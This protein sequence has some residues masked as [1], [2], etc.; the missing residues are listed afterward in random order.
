M[1]KISNIL[2]SRNVFAIANFN[3]FNAICEILPKN[4]KQRETSLFPGCLP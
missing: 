4:L 2:T 3:I 1:F